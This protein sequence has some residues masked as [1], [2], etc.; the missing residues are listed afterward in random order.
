MR[1]NGVC[2]NLWAVGYLVIANADA[3][4]TE[5]LDD[6]VTALRS[7]GGCEVAWTESPEDVDDVLAGDQKDTVVIAGGDGS[8]HLVVNR[9][10]RL[11]QLSRPVGILPMGTGNDLARGLGLPFDP[12]ECVEHLVSAGS[13][14]LPLMQAPDGEVAVNNAHVGLGV[15]AAHKGAEWKDRLG[16][17]AYAAGSVAEGI[18]FDGFDARIT[19][20]GQQVHQGPCLVMMVMVGPSAGGGFR[21]LSDVR[22]TEPVLDVL[23]VQ[24]DGGGRLTLAVSALRDQLEDQDEVVIARGSRVSV[25][26]GAE[27]WELDG[28][29]RSWNDAVELAITGDAWTVLA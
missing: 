26:T 27:E 10:A 15:A 21:P 16:S 3:G 7:H 17:F 5:R 14:S 13:R 9:L 12:V 28:E 4:S 20:D 19:V 24:D 22:V 11:G 1:E 25:V 2:G 23:V 18:S 6:A 8:I 29:F